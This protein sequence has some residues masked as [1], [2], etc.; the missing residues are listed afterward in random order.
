MS[1]T[2]RFSRVVAVLLSA[3]GLV[4]LASS[5][6][7]A[8]IDLVTVQVNDPSGT[9]L[10]NVPVYLQGEELTDFLSG[11]TDLTGLASAMSTSGSGI[12]E[13]TYTL[14]VSPNQAYG[15]TGC[16]MLESYEATVTVSAAAA[17]VNGSGQNVVALDTVTLTAASR[18]VTVNVTDADSGVAIEGVSV[19]AFSMKEMK[20]FAPMPDKETAEE[21]MSAPGWAFGTT[22]VNGDFSFAVAEDNTDPWN[23]NVDPQFS[24]DEDLRRYTSAMENAV[25][26]ADDGETLVNM[27]LQQ[28]D[29]TITATLVDG[30]G[31]AVTLASDEFLSVNCFEPWNPE[32][33]DAFSSLFFFGSMMGG[34]SSVTMYVLGD[35]QYDCN[36]FMMD[37]AI[38]GQRVDVPADGAVEIDLVML[39]KNAEIKFRFVDKNGEVLKDVSGSANAFAVKDSEG[40]N[41]WGDY[42]WAN[43]EKGVATLSAID[44]YTYDVS[45]WL[46]EGGSSG[47]K[48]GPGGDS[49]SGEDGSSPDEG[50]P[51]D[52]SG[53]FDGGEPGE[54]DG[55]L[56]CPEGED[57]SGDFGDGEPGDF[58]GD[59]GGSFKPMITGIHTAESGTQ[60]L[61]NYEMQ[62]VVANADKSAVVDLTIKVADAT[63]VV[64]LLDSEGDP[65]ENGWVDG[66]E[67]DQ[68]L[69]G[70]K[71]LKGEFSHGWG[72]FIGGSTNA[73][74]V[75][76]I[77][78]AS[79]TY[80]VGA[81]TPNAF[82]G[83][84][85]PP[86][87]QTIT[88]ASG[89][90]KELTLQERE[91]DWTIDITATI[92]GG[93]TLDFVSCFGFD[94]D[95]GLNNFTNLEDGSGSL[96]VVTNASFHVG[97]MGYG[98]TTFYRSD[99]QTVETGK[100][101]GGSSEISVVLS[102][103]GDFF[104]DQ[105]TT[106]DATSATT[107]T[108]PDG[109]ST[110]TVP[111]NCLATEGNVVASIGS[112]TGFSVTDDAYPT[113]V[114]ELT[115]TDSTG[116]EI[117]EVE[118]D[119]A[120]LTWTQPYD[121]E[122]LED[123]GLTEKT[124]TGIGHY[125]EDNNA[126]ESPASTSVDTDENTV[127]STITE[128]SS[129]GLLGD[130]GLS[131][132]KVTKPKAPKAKKMK[133]KKV[134]KQSAKLKWTA[135]EGATYYKVKLM[136]MND[137]NEYELVKMF[138]NVTDSM[139]QLGKKFLDA[140]MQY[141]YQVKSCNA[142]GCS[143][144]GSAKSFMT[145]D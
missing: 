28:T 116:S 89:A 140:G 4:L 94:P 121:E 43:V 11:Y 79:G 31:N 66:F 37:S 122:E 132:A 5:A 106:I 70:G 38:K 110:L 95:N 36:A 22:D 57:C 87:R 49:G 74:G 56:T 112:A 15:C 77:P 65:V 58:G 124:L 6:R 126:W 143:K 40:N 19:S 138:K 133:V 21:E 69:K 129:Y 99:D 7:A 30:E 120:G 3:L 109:E 76:E 73:K 29:A 26:V 118:D 93:G 60:Y 78:V 39:E 45:G 82:N 113:D 24:T 23:I 127:S 80:E 119:C 61:Q 53:D 62:Q 25:E 14:T 84:I 104:E 108:A 35:K 137:T 34:S 96:A 105:S 123:L 75:A 67:A 128:F 63:L 97:C 71:K 98:S 141:Q 92:E 10:A 51:D 47:G 33:M 145:L 88:V 131:T 8:T 139:K 114:Y 100:N 48:P 59:D 44:G 101:K 136:V 55:E 41:F 144:F 115:F 32:Q 9:G 90:S 85:L 107:I 20:G 125:N 102:E 42:S 64:T 17:T 103:G 12:S 16:S 46:N 86:A 1:Y 52:G 117:T 81:F 50:M 27:S 83:T 72:N 13:G 68:K 142:A 111:A 2:L 54:G 130:K 18:F 134:K 135:V 91:T